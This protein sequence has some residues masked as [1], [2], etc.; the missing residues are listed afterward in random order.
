MVQSELVD[1]DL[2]MIGGDF[3]ASAL[4]AFKMRRVVGRA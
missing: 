3:P 1:P 2:L 4:N